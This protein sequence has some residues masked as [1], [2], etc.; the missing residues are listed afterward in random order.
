MMTY[1][2]RTSGASVS[3]VS[4]RLA[5]TAG[6]PFA[7][8]FAIQAISRRTPASLARLRSELLPV[9]SRSM[10]LSICGAWRL[11]Y[12]GARASGS[13]RPCHRSSRTCCFAIDEQ[14]VC[15]S[16]EQRERDFVCAVG[17][18]RRPR[19]VLIDIERFGNEI[20]TSST[21]SS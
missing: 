2:S 7:P 13:R 9:L 10:D 20:R 17:L 11:A 15:E 21:N 12:R 14:E 3:G 19:L 1:R 6:R 5:D 18:H 8:E 4:L 16:F